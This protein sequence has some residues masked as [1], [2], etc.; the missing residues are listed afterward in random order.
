VTISDLF[1]FANSLNSNLANLILILSLYLFV[2]PS[3]QRL[4]LRNIAHLL[5]SIAKLLENN[6][7][8]ILV[9]KNRNTIACE[10][11][12]NVKFNKVV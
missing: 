1:L 11:N 4:R 8:K 12:C 6:N 7:V 10:M 2:E 3:T 5:K 9:F